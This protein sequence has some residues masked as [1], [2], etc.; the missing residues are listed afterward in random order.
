MTA[1]EDLLTQLLQTSENTLA[2]L[3]AMSEE[4]LGSYVDQRQHIF[5]QLQQQSWEAHRMEE[6]GAI[7]KKIMDNDTQIQQKMKQV[8]DQAM[9]QLKKLNK[10]KTQQKYGQSGVVQSMFYDEKK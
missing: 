7:I 9:N 6:Y 4:Q 8:R 1:T 10:L 2:K 3:D 5:G